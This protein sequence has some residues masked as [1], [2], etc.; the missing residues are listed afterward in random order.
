MRFAYLAAT[1]AILALAGCSLAE[2]AR[3]VLWGDDHGTAAVVIAGKV[4]TKN[5]LQRFFDRRLSDFRDPHKA[6][7]V[8]SNLLETFVE[9]KLLL[10]RAEGL[11]VEPN[12]QLLQSTMAR[13]AV[14]NSQPAGPPSAPDPDAE[15]ER[16]VAEN[17]KIQQY[18]RDYPLRNVTVSEAECEEY[19]RQHLEDYVRN[20]VVHVREILVDDRSQAEKILSSLKQQKNKNFGELARVYSKAPSAA[21]GGDLGIFQRGDLPENLEKVVFRL[22]PTMVSPIVQTRYGYHIFLLEEKIL[23]HQQK[24]YEV[25]D[26]IQE[27]LL[28]QRERDLIARDVDSLMKQIPVE[29]RLENL[30]FKYLGNRLSTGGGTSP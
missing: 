16:S 12:P 20:D 24:F 28:L 19:Y 27:K 13:I 21:D 30:D 14:E 9:E 8:K 10:L 6:D 1:P 17:L 29:I 26:D 18:L 23:A 7:Q 25:K 11:Q 4:F 22:A 3:S 15:I 2:R 5:D